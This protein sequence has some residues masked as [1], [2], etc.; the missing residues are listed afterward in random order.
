MLA[1]HLIEEVANLIED[2]VI[3]DRG[4]MILQSPVEDLVSKGYSISGLE[5]EVEDY[6]RGKDVI[7][8]ERLG[9]LKVAYIMGAVD[10]S[11]LTDRLTVSPISLQKLFVKLT[12]SEE[13]RI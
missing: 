12:E 13:E 7:G 4:R 1:T 6:C 5:Q 11:R 8:E 3:I 2:V 10:R 9:G